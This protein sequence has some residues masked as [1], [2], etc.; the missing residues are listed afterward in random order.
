MNDTNR[1]IVKLIYRL[2]QKERVYYQ[3]L[4]IYYIISALVFLERLIFPQKAKNNLL[5]GF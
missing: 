3:F 2:L 5:Q 4:Y 1:V